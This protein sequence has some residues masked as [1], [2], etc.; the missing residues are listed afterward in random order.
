[1]RELTEEDFKKGI[2]NPFF[3]KLCRKVEVAVSHENYAIYED[4]AK[5]RGVTPEMVMQRCLEDY[6]KI[7]E[8]HE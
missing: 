8:A 2:K 7:L 1:M 3:D 5:K 4:I 6:V